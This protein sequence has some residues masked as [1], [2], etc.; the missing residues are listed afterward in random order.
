MFFTAAIE[1]NHTLTQVFSVHAFFLLQPHYHPS[2][3]T[4]HVNA[5]KHSEEFQGHGIFQIH[6]SAMIPDQP[7][8][9]NRSPQKTPESGAKVG[10]KEDEPPPFLFGGKKGN[11]FPPQK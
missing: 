11:E 9:R 7:T 1:Y 6:L 8:N 5:E 10:G 3:N 2:E 4:N